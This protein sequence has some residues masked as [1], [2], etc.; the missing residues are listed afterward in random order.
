MN[1]YMWLAFANLMELD[2][3]DI[4]GPGGILTPFTLSFKGYLMEYCRATEEDVQTVLQLF[5]R[6]LL[7]FTAQPKFA[8][9]VSSC[10]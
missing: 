7:S 9:S 8:C 10:V 3:Q 2:D 5:R 4:E 6:I 1:V